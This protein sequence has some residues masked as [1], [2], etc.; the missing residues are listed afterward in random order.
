MAPK[1]GTATVHVPAPRFGACAA[2]KN[3]QV[4]PMA[5]AWTKE[6]AYA[7]QLP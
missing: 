1:G 6:P 7:L 2:E 4:V 3:Q 5:I